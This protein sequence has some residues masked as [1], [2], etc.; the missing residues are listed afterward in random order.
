[1]KTKLLTTVLAVGMLSSCS[2]SFF[3]TSNTSGEDD[4]YYN[5]EKK[6][7]W[8]IQKFDYLSRQTILIKFVIILLIALIEL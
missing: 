2:S 7:E 5:S 1:M 6:Y 3:L 8:T 4:I